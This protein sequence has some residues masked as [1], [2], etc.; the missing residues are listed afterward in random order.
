MRF[1]AD[2][3]DAF[4]AEERTCGQCGVA[5]SRYPTE[6]MGWRR[7]AQYVELANRARAALEEAAGK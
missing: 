1:Y 2:A 6:L 4:N 3:A 5:Q 7:Y